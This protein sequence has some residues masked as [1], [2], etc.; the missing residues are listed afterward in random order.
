M[1][2]EKN[3][4]L[5]VGFSRNLSDNKIEHLAAA[6]FSNNTRLERLSKEDSS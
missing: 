1:K 3:V 5:Y 4:I 6:V 2:L